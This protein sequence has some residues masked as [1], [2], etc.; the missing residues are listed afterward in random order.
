[1]S[2][3]VA[4]S[5]RSDV[6][7]VAE[8]TDR[9][10]NRIESDPGLMHCM[11]AGELSNFKH[12]SSGHMYFTLKD[13]KSRVRGIMFA[14]R[15]R[16]LRF[17]PKDGMRVICTGSIGVFERDGQYQLYVDD[18]QPDGVGALYVAFL[19]LRDK[20][21][22][23]GLFD[24]A[25]KRPLPAH[26]MRI[27]VVTSPT[28]AVI[29]DI[30]TTLSRRY[31]LA[32]VVLS[33]AAVQGPGAAETIVRALQRLSDLHQSGTSIDV[34]IV[35]RGGGS[36]EELWPFNEEA[37]ARA[38]ATYPIPV[39][40]AVGHETDTTICDFVADVRAATPTAAAELAA[41]NLQ[42][43]AAQL[44]EWRKRSATALRFAHAARTQSLTALSKTAVLRDPM[45]LV[46][47]RKQTVDYLEARA[48][49]FIQTPVQH[50]GRKLSAITERLY[51]VDIRRRMD[52][53]KRSVDA[54]CERASVAVHRKSER[55]NA[56]LEQ[57]ISQLQALNP[58]AVLSRGYSV[59]LDETTDT[60]IGSVSNLVGG[61][62][63][64]LQMQ[65]GFVHAHI[66]GEEGDYHERG[67]QLRL[68]L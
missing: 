57:R 43:V 59:I 28:G 50:A 2:T 27:G 54:H 48:A 36:L 46:D 16:F 67:K 66:D 55:A 39:I 38:I 22:Q 40:S 32:S 13:D 34:V 29:R 9:I 44:Q 63:V 41:P 47:Q 52:Q 45:K 35:G 60:V 64:R 23:E 49:R 62:R 5:E 24:P 19:Q 30:C 14:G 33:P 53:A 17:A 18:M 61:Q 10:K 12:H 7:T 3:V 58:L 68:D 37:V 26:P 11:V 51:R 15:N 4:H 20:L 56:T 8:L 42:E 6:W 21:E 25:R 31:P 65:D 1:M